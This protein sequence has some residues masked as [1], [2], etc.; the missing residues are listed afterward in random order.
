M[1]SIHVQYIVK[2]AE[3]FVLQCTGE[4]IKED[5]IILIRSTTQT[6]ENTWI[7]SFSSGGALSGRGLISDVIRVISVES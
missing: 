7:M 4:Y 6:C 3:H 1:H 5:Y 2:C